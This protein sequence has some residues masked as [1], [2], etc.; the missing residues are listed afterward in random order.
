MTVILPKNI[1]S[2]ERQQILRDLYNKMQSE[3]RKLKSRI[4]K[5][6]RGTVNFAKEGEKTALEIQKEMRDDWD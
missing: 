6:V 5:E 2:S 1:S 3:K 4:L